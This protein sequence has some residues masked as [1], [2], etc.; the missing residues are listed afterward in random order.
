MPC[1]CMA[2]SLQRIECKRL[3]WVPNQQRLSDAELDERR[4]FVYQVVT[5]SGAPYENHSTDFLAFQMQYRPRWGDLFAYHKACLPTQVWPAFG[6]RAGQVMF[7]D[8]AGGPARWE[9]CSLWTL[10]P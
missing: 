8:E 4:R 5:G 6:Q 2:R 7:W 10:P 3:F 1:A 9:C